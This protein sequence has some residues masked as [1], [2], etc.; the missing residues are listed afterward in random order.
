MDNLAKVFWI[1][2]IPQVSFNSC[3]TIS[4][5]PTNRASTFS[6]FCGQS[7]V[8]C[9]CLLESMLSKKSIKNFSGRSFRDRKEAESVAGLGAGDQ[10]IGIEAVN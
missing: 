8:R 4:T 9:P 1:A 10:E 3:Q 7:F 5:H 2:N 6:F